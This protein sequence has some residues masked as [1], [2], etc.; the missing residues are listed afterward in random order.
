M[1]KCNSSEI[2]PRAD[3]EKSE[4]S[5]PGVKGLRRNKKISRGPGM[6]LYSGFG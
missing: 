4:K 1:L 6:C 3:A 2:S 5:V